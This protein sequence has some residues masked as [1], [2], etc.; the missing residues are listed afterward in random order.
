MS[1]AILQFVF[2]PNPGADL[3]GVLELCKEAAG[4]WK[5]HGAAVSLWAVQVG[6][7]GNMVFAARFDSSTKLGATLEAVNGDPA[8]AVWR[9]KILKSGSSSWVRSNQAYEIPI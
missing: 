2:R 9:A 7:V 4:I 3:A 8:M 1:A 5:R 6:E